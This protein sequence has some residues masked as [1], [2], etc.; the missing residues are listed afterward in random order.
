MELL[1]RNWHKIYD[2]VL[3]LC[4]PCDFPPVSKTH[5]T[6]CKSLQTMFLLELEVFLPQGVHSV[7]HLLDKLHLRVAKTVLV[8]HIISAA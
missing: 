5:S 8:G 1:F 3:G 2:R 6:A 4:C 7:N